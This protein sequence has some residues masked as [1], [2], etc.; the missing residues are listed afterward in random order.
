M[1]LWAPLVVPVA[2]A[3]ALLAAEEADER[4]EDAAAE[5]LVAAADAD[6]ARVLVLVAVAAEREL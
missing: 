3:R 6:E 2:L 5:T 1:T 4:T